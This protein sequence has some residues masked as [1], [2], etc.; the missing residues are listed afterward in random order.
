MGLADLGRRWHCHGRQGGVGWAAAWL[1]WERQSRK[2]AHPWGPKGALSQHVQVAQLITHTCIG[3]AGTLLI[4]PM[5][6]SPP[7]P[8]AV[9]FY[10]VY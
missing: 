8:P 1:A 10:V 2:S 5:M 9:Q 3:T 7:P 4:K 6:G